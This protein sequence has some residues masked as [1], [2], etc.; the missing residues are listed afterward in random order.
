M[1][2]KLIYQGAEAIILQKGNEVI[3]QRIKKS[4]R[5]PEIDEKLRK[6]RTRSEAKLLEKA[7]K[8]IPVPK[9]IKVDEKTKEIVMEFIDGKKLSDNLDN[10]SLKKQK[11]ICLEIGKETAK[12]HDIGIIHG[13]LTT[14]NMILVNLNGDKKSTNRDRSK[15]KIF[16]IDFGLGFNRNK[17]EDKAVD[18]HLLK[19]ALEA[20]HFQNW[21]E[22]FNSI[23]Q[24]YSESKNF[25][26][27]FER[28]KKVELRGRYKH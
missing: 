25:K 13:D 23:L 18:L 21:Q 17:I 28:L 9:V 14:S 20:K 5:L 24:G 6:L 7:S 16:F 22:L 27:T 3:K 4:Y 26:E 10:F 8:V 19:Q 15:F 1:Q 2:Q 11:Q 12:L